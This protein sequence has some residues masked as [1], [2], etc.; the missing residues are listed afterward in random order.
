[1]S[2]ALELFC[3]AVAVTMPLSAELS[4]LIGVGGWGKPIS[5]SVMQRGTSVCP[6]W[7]SP[8]T[9]DL[10]ADTN[11]CFRII[12]SVWIG[13]FSGSGRFESFYGSIVSE[14]R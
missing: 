10:A 6:L 13:L 8:P 7:N 3:L 9:S 5:W 11:A 12:H 2:I 14:L 1:M 4:V